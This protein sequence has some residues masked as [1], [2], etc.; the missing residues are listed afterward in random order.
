MR[1]TTETTSRNKARPSREAAKECSPRHKPWE[2]SQKEASPV[3]TTEPAVNHCHPE[4]SLAK[5]EAIRQTESKDPMTEE[6]TTGDARNF[7]TVVRFF[8]D[9]DTELTPTF[10]RAADSLSCRFKPRS[11]AR[12]QP[13][14]QAVGSSDKCSSSEGAKETLPCVRTAVTF[15]VATTPA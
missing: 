14:A 10:N 1:P 9:H 5:S 8:D 6:G 7:R 2:P 12:M 15:Y 13:T 4:R 3:G 11:G